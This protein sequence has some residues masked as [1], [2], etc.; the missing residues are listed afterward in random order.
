MN[1]FMDNLKQTA[2]LNLS[3][4]IDDINVVKENLSTLTS[5]DTSNISSLNTDDISSALENVRNTST[6]DDEFTN[7]I[8][9]NLLE[10]INTDIQSEMLIPEQ[11]KT[12]VSNYVEE[13]TTE[14]ESIIPTSSTYKD[15]LDGLVDLIPSI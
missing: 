6:F 10:N 4:L 14:L 1:T 3:T 12:D 7:T 5:I 9:I 11:T 13:K 8:V 15:I 2:N